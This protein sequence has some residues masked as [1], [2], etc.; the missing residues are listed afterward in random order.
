MF[1]IIIIAHC[2]STSC[3]HAVL[4]WSVEVQVTGLLFVCFT[5]IGKA[6][7]DTVMDWLEVEELQ[8]DN[9]LGGCR[10]RL[11]QC[12]VHQVPITDHHPVLVEG[13]SEGITC[14]SG[15][16]TDVEGSSSVEVVASWASK[17]RVAW[18]H[19]RRWYQSKYQSEACPLT[20]MTET[21]CIQLIQSQSANKGRKGPLQIGGS[22]L[23]SYHPYIRSYHGYTDRLWESTHIDAQA[24][25][26][27]GT[28]PILSGPTV[29]TEEAI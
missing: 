14:V 24:T 15:D 3:T 20:R 21:M 23:Q 27:E 28:L 12:C 26:Q 7:V 9:L 29:N 17:C 8:L 18:L 16:A 25:N 11:C 1:A 5:C 6:V 2:P 4:T 19:F 10:G 13:H 22:E